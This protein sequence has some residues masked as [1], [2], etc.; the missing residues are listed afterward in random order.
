MKSASEIVKGVGHIFDRRSHM[1]INIDHNVAADDRGR[2][3]SKLLEVSFIAPKYNGMDK[4]AELQDV[5]TLVTR[6]FDAA[7]LFYQEADKRGCMLPL[8]SV[9]EVNAAN[10]EAR[11]DEPAKAAA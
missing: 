3:A 5:E 8:P 2:L 7:D 6:A 10:A 9:D 4:P 1:R 11:A